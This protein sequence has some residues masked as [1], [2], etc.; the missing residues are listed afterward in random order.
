MLDTQG[1]GG[2]GLFALRRQRAKA[3]RTAAEK[4]KR[5]LEAGTPASSPSNAS[6]SDSSSLADGRPSGDDLARCPPPPQMR[7]QG[8]AHALGA[9]LSDHPMSLPG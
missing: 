8:P 4:A 2:A 7:A 3:A 5:A 6:D 1:G 9:P